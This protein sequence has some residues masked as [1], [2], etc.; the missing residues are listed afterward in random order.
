MKRPISILIIAI[1]LLI[2]CSCNNSTFSSSEVLYLNSED[3]IEESS[4]YVTSE[5]Q[6][7]ENNQEK[8]YNSTVEEIAEKIMSVSEAQVFSNDLIEYVEKAKEKNEKHLKENINLS[9][10]LKVTLT[11]KKPIT[12]MQI[13]ELIEKYNIEAEYLS[14]QIIS[15]SDLSISTFNANIKVLS[16]SEVV[17]MTINDPSNQEM[18]YLGLTSL[19][20]IMNIND[21]SEIQSDELIFLAELCQA[22]DNNYLTGEYQHDLGW[23]L[24]NEKRSK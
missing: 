22:Q 24:S 7:I 20:G 12:E 14:G 8:K 17:D 11:F 5:Q 15:S 2:L 18:L 9:Q 3:Q 6:N 19:K 16:I 21:F 10:K 4:G 23:K 1:I 13:N